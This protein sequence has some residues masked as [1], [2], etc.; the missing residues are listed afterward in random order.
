LARRVRRDL[1][2]KKIRK[3]VEQKL[4]ESR[5]PTPS[6][7]PSSFSFNRFFKRTFY[8]LILASIGFLVYIVLTSPALLN[9]FSDQNPTV[10]RRPNLQG[11]SKTISS[12]TTAEKQ[13]DTQP[14]IQPVKQKMQVEVLNGCGI[15]GIAATTTDYLRKSE[16]DV[17]FSGNY[18]RSDVAQ[19]MVLDRVGNKSHAEKIADILGIKYEQIKTEVNLSRQLDVTVVLG[20]D[21]FELKPFKP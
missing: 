7:K 2:N 12:K 10:P 6:Q 11:K 16:I 17:V 18:T 3:I 13:P 14:T 4:T 8:L 9:L 19:S 15:R 5:K 21:Y 1:S 20:K